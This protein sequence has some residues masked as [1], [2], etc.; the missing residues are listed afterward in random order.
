MIEDLEITFKYRNKVF[1]YIFGTVFK[2][3]DADKEM[4]KQFN[5]SEQSIIEHKKVIQKFL[6]K[7]IKPK[8]LKNK[9][10]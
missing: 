1:K 9:L 2:L 5:Q 10:K 3:R 6:L 4:F 8:P 7:G